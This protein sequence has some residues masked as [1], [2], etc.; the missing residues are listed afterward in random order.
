[1]NIV[2]LKDYIKGDYEKIIQILEKNNFYDISYNRSKNE[3]R[4]AREYG[5]NNTSIRINVDTLSSVCFSKNV[6]GDIITLIQ[7]KNQLGFK[8]TIN[9]ISSILGISNVDFNINKYM[10][11]GGYYKK[12]SKNQDINYVDLLTYPEDILDQYSIKPNLLFYKDGIDW[13]VQKKYLLGYDCISQRIVVPWRNING[14]IVGIMGRYNHNEIPEGISKWLPIIAFPK[15]Y[16]VFGYSE[17]YSNIIENDFCIIG[18]S[19]K[20]PM[21]LESKGIKYSISVGGSSIS[22]MQSQYIKSL[23]VKTN[24]LA[25]DEGLDEEHIINEAKKLKIENAFYSNNVGYIYDEQ[26]KILKKGSKLSPS[27][28]N[29]FN[30]LIKNYVRWI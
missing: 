7:H 2:Q 8:Q 24:I 14:D 17:N 3:I 26:G 19:E 15:S 4:C 27:D 18:E 25:F 28:L 10:P 5:R 13:N 29:E 30:V 9:N 21:Q 6:K 16:V 1:M 23:N 22:T 12:I 11:F 20:L